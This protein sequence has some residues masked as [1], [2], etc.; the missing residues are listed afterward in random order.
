MA[1]TVPRMEK[2]FQ[3]GNRDVVFSRVDC[4]G[5]HKSFIKS[6]IISA[7]REISNRE[8]L[9]VFKVTLDTRQLGTSAT[10]N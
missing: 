6:C 7:I 5:R 10:R 3:L 8:K 2:D 9:E 1:K 4:L